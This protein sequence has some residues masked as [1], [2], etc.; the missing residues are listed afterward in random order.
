MAAIAAALIG[1]WTGA[2][3]MLVAVVV[4]VSG[5]ARHLNS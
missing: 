2:A 5:A 4:A 3:V 1:T